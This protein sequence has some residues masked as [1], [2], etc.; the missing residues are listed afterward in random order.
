MIFEHKFEQRII[1]IFFDVIVI[2]AIISYI[3]AV[4][5]SPGR[6][7]KENNMKFRG[8][9]CSL[10][11]N[12]IIRM[13]HHCGFIANCVGLFNLK[14]HYLLCFYRIN[15]LLKYTG[16]CGIWYEYFGYL[17]LFKYCQIRDNLINFIGYWSILIFSII[18]LVILI[19]PIS[20]TISQGISITK[21]KTSMEF[22]SQFRNAWKYD[23]GW[24]SNWEYYFGKFNYCILVRKF[25]KSIGF[26]LFLILN[27]I[28]N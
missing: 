23:M 1:I 24:V 9:Y 2:L 12:Y 16:I 7:N 19:L 13:D 22:F 26:C 20:L 8:F 4:I 5:T 15:K 28:M 25:E 21:N 11:K 17:F 14:F 3:R 10:C 6:I 27:F 18:V